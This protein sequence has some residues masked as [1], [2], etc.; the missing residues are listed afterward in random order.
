M[1]IEKLLNEIKALSPEQKFEL[2]RR[3]EE[4][5][6]LDEDQSWYWTPEWQAAEKE[7]DKDIT[8]GRVHQ[9]DNVDDL[10][11]SL[12]EQCNRTSDE[13]Y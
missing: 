5:A 12:H 3:L 4:K 8:A 2:A 1:A 13:E 7:A 9:Y 6:V 11:K 10:I